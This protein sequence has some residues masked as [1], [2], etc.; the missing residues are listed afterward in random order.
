MR[1][2]FLIVKNSDG[3]PPPRVYSDS[4]DIEGEEPVL[5]YN[6]QPYEGY[7]AV[8][9]EPVADWDAAKA[10]TDKRG[11]DLTKERY[12]HLR[13][14]WPPQPHGVTDSAPA[15]PKATP[16]PRKPPP[17]LP[18]EVHNHNPINADAAMAAV[19]ALS[20]GV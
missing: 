9:A 3:W 4:R 16:G 10:A 1:Y 5:A 12:I 14:H 20:K 2:R 7:T 15:Q 13:G 8:A 18:V 19:R 17:Q 6:L 11:F